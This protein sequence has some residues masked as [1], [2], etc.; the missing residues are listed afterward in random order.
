MDKGRHILGTFEEALRSLRNSVL[1]MASL[2]ERSLERA[3]TGL[4]N[5]DDDLCAVAI[6]DD[7]EIDQLEI[8]IDKDGVDILLRFQPVASDLRRVVS[9]MKM[10]SN[11][12]RMADQATNIA[13][14]ARKLNQHPLLVEIDLI[15]PMD[16]QAMSMF[17][18]S[19]NAYVREDVDL[20]RAIVPRDEKLDELNRV[21]SRK[22]IERMAQDPEQLR[23]YLNLIFI[24]RCLERV[25]DHATNI[26][27]DAVY[28]AA[29]EDIRHQH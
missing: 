11:L 4:F 27:E 16:E 10:S 26:A 2:T 13:R 22:L 8:Q 24:G 21:A 23:G 12:E 28:A 17:K 6:A 20:A 29:A 25:G 7:E 5:R 9:A 19:V 3:M 1:M 15:K 18:E 14:R